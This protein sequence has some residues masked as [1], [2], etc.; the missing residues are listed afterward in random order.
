METLTG[1]T[2]LLRIPPGTQNGRIFRLAGQGLPRFAA[3][4][5]ATCCVRVRVVLPT[6][7][8]DEA[9]TPGPRLRRP[10]RPA[11]SRHG[12]PAETASTA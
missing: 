12:Q 6:G 4:A 11:R 8:D 7:L 5:A 2:L 1:K 9:R 3:E 10:H